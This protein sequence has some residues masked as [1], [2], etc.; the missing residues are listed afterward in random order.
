M[1]LV[2]QINAEK[3]ALIYGERITISA[4]PNAVYCIGK[5]KAKLHGIIV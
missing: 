4:A 1:R 3:N 2:R 5:S